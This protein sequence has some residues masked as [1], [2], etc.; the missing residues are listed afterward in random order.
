MVVTPPQIPVDITP[1]PEVDLRAAIRTIAKRSYSDTNKNEW[2]R[3]A[4]EIAAQLKTRKRTVVS[5]LD[6]M[7][8]GEDPKPRRSGGGRKQRIK[9]GTQKSN[10]LVNGLWSGW[11]GNNT[12]KVIN[13]LGLTPGKKPVH[14][15]TVVLCANK[16]T[17]WCAA[18]RSTPRPGVVTR[19][20]SGPGTGHLQ[21][22]PRVDPFSEGSA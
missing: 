4:G 5:V 18:R 1:V 2:G 9:E 19:T 8:R 6:R 16:T 3:V 11:D 12:A 10:R 21:A 15:T 7:Q 13:A 17:E 20:P 22:I 14:R